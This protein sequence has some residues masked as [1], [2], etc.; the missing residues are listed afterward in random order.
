MSYTS[1]YTGQEIDER[2]DSIG[3]INTT[4]RILWEGNSTTAIATNYSAT[5][6]LSESIENYDKIGLYL[7]VHSSK[8]AF[9]YIYREIPTEVII[10]FINSPD[11]A[12]EDKVSVCWGYGTST[13]YFDIQK[14]ST[15][16]NL[17]IKASITNATKIVGIKYQNTSTN[18]SADATPVGTIISV[19]RK[20]APDGYLIC[21][22]REVN[23]SDYT[24]L[25]SMFEEEFGSKNVYGGDG[26]TTFALPDLRNEFLRGYG[27]LSN[28]IG[29]HQEAT[30]IPHVWVWNASTTNGAIAPNVNV[31][32]DNI[33][34]NAD[35]LNMDMVS[36]TV[37]QRSY[38]ELGSS[39]RYSYTKEIDSA[40]DGGS[41]LAYSYTSRPTNVAVL[42]CIKY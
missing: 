30:E 32:K 17:A 37:A 21:D 31:N 34:D 38:I 25:A 41:R 12:E 8:T 5:I 9:R 39:K 26:I 35:V 7:V 20:K 40:V 19:M 4:Q 3:T 2:L 18:N 36:D 14:S 24:A 11:T 6:E 15:V 23:I 10:D 42:Y 27:E 29:M 22:G 1:K 16:N 13:D 33:V 28:E